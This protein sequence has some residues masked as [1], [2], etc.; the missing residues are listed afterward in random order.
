MKT[1]ICT[2]GTSI[3]TKRGI[4][5]DR[6]LN[7]DLSVWKKM[8]DDIE[9]VK[10]RV[11]EELCRINFPKEL[12][13]TSAEIKSLVKMQ[14][15]KNDTVILISS[16]TVDGKLCAELVRS[17]LIERGIC[18]DGSI[19]IKEIQGLQATDGTKFQRDGLKNLLNYLISLEHQNIIFNL[20]GGY[21]SIV[22][23]IALM[24]MIFNKPVKYI[25]EDSN[26]VITLPAVPMILDD[27]LIL[28]IEN[29]LRKI[30]NE[31]AISISE[32]QEG[33]DY[34]DHRFDCFVE[35]LLRDERPASEKYNKLLR[36]G[37]E[38]HGLAKIKPIA[39]KLLHSPFV[40]SVPNSCDNQS[41]SKVWIKSLTATE[42]INH[43]QREAE[44]ICIVTDIN[45]DAGYSF[46]IETTARNYNE[47][48]KIADILNRKYFKSWI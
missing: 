31:T 20:T 48:K 47:N 42:A 12:D 11:S 36:Q 7:A 22:P 30:E 19:Q 5:L 14:L 2:C 13:E 29:K 26:D 9:A 28:G 23:Y 6:F 38:H 44:G 33:I 18:S 46:L 1:Y 16:D 32:W 15:D 37:V 25:H 27:D 21:K 24:G 35:E 34:H 45:S 3:S 4:N 10:D 40:K 17:F 8:K 43:L 39:N 41:K